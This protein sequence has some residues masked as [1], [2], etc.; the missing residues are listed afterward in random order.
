MK[1]KVYAV[2]Y[3]DNHYNMSKKLN[4]F[5]AKYIGKADYVIETGPRDLGESFKRKCEDILKEKRGGGYWAWKP[6]IMLKVLS[7]MNW[8][9]FLIYT[10]A[11]LIYVN[12]ISELIRQLERDK[13]DIFL[14][15]GFAPCKDWCK[16]DA[17][18][19]MGCD[20]ESAKQSVMVSGGYVLVRKSRE[21]IRFLN[22]WKKYSEDKRII[23]DAP[24]SCGLENYSGF[25]ENRHDQSILSLLAWKYGIEPYKAVSHVDEPRMHIRVKRTGT[26]AYKYS[27][28][29]RVDFMYREH[30]K[31]GYKKSDYGRIFINTHLQDM[32]TR[33][34]LMGLIKSVCWAIRCDIWGVLHDSEELS[35]A[36]IR[37][38]R[39]RSSE[40]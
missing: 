9:D 27:F 20:C 3:S 22:E 21:S 19:L 40:L 30:L 18:V 2:S 34:F 37:A 23:T 6:Y 13:K 14:S 32:D 8:G 16:R 17:F 35:K 28:H 25:H 33:D 38:E 15:Y 12:R 7:K 29:K 5:T 31:E 26:D 10:D 24:N 36:K 39:L 11:G 4:L 1:A